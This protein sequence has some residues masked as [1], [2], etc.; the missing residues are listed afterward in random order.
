MQIHTTKLTDVRF[1][2]RA[3]QGLVTASRFLGEAAI[4]ADKW[5]HAFP[6]F[7]PERLGAVIQ[8]FTRISDTKF[9][10]KTQVYHPDILVFIDPTIIN[11]KKYY[12]G[13]E[14]GGTV[15]FNAKSIPQ[16]ILTMLKQNDAK[17]WIVDGD[18]I[19]RKHIGRTVANTVMLGALVR[20]TGVVGLQNIIDVMYTKFKGEVGDKN[21]AAIREAYEEVKLIE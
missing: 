12:K 9:T 6:D 8:A 19:S 17:I 3:G 10:L 5:V 2:G 11:E 20:A 16:D 15:L 7:G 18:S 13:L 1:H 14:T 4:K 21:A